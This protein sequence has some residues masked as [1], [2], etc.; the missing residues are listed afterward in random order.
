MKITIL[1]ITVKIKSKI[2]H[3]YYSHHLLCYIL[4]YP[5]EPSLIPLLSIYYTCAKWYLH[6]PPH[7][8][9]L[10]HQDFSLFRSF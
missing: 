1:S 10:I 5:T 8:I 3:K 6:S 4:D 7:Q 9:L 2:I